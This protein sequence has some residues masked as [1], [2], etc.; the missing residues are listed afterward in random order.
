MG[1]SL[2]DGMVRAR[3]RPGEGDALAHASMVS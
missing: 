2:V 1:V 3:A